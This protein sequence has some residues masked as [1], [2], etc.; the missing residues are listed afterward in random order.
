MKRKEIVGEGEGEGVRG[1]DFIFNTRE[2]YLSLTFCFSR[3]VLFSTWL[4]ENVISAF[5]SVSS[6]RRMK[7]GKNLM[8]N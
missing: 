3:V 7:S 1:Y 5:N 2:N 6:L 8:C 4:T